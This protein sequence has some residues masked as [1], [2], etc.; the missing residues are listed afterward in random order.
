MIR[1]NPFDGKSIYAKFVWLIYRRMMSRE[2]FSHGDVMADKL[3]YK[4]AAKLPYS[5]SKCPD[6]GELRK[7]FL[8]MLKLMEEKA[9]K[10]C[11]ESRG[12]NRNKVFRYIGVA[13]KPLEDYQNA[14]AISDIRTYAQFCED[15]AGFFPRSWL[16][17]FFEDTLDLLKIKQRKKSG[18]QM[19]TSSIDRELKNV[20][21]L[22]FL[23]ETIRDK[24]VL[25]IKY[26]PYEEDLVE[27]EFHPHLLKEHNGRWF[28]FGYAKG[29]EPDFGFNLA[30][31]RIE[32]V[33]AIQPQ[34]AI[35]YVPA[36]K[37]FY[38]NYFKNI[39]GVSHDKDSKI[40]KIRIR[41]HGFNMYKLTETKPIH[42]SQEGILPYGKYDDDEYG[43]FEVNVEVNKE[44]IGRILQMGP[45][46]EIISPPEVRSLFKEKIEQMNKLYQ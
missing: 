31:D 41:A 45:N 36:P 42:N 25:S 44:F 12:N 29:K 22:P 1:K 6:N 43:E 37:E 35:T 4:S 23:Y 21:L 19:I 46:L 17:H 40:Y 26:K 24:Q 13:D 5:I 27:L 9:G 33:E 39:I 28:L 30:L 3:G 34:M 2:W 14:S 7:A 11:V 10:G 20:N 16:E 15:S 8:D 18:R 38:D 32:E